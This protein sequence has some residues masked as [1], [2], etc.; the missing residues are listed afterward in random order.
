M[1]VIITY[2]VLLLPAHRT[3]TTYYHLATEEQQIKNTSV[4][5]W[6]VANAVSTTNTALH[7]M[8]TNPLF[9]SGREQC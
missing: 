2:A 4:C 3:P 6:Q 8:G 1:L 9:P 7:V 5:P